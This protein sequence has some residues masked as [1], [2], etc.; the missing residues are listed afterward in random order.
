MNYEGAREKDRRSAFV[1]VPGKEDD[2]DGPFGCHC[3][4]PAVPIPHVERCRP[5]AQ[6]CVSERVRHH[7]GILPAQTDQRDRYVFRTPFW[8]LEPVL[9]WTR[10]DQARFHANASDY[11]MNV[12]LV[13]PSCQGHERIADGVEVLFFASSLEFFPKPKNPA[14]EIIRLHRVQV[15]SFED[16]PQFVCKVGPGCHVSFL[17]FDGS[18]E[19]SD[20][21]YH[22]S[23]AKYSMEKERELGI[24]KY[25]RGWLNNRDAPLMNHKYLRKLFELKSGEGPCDILCKVVQVRRQKRNDGKEDIL[26]FVWDGTDCVPQP[27]RSG[28]AESVFESGASLA[29][30]LAEGWG[31]LELSCE[32]IKSLKPPRIGTFLPVCFWSHLESSIP[33]VGDCI[34]LKSVL[35]WVHKGQTC[36]LFSSRSNWSYHQPEFMVEYS[37]RTLNNLVSQWAPENTQDLLTTTD[38]EH[39]PWST[40]REV[41]VDERPGKYRVLVQLVA[42]LPHDYNDWCTKVGNGKGEFPAKLLPSIGASPKATW[43]YSCKFLLRDATGTIEALLTGTSAEQF[44]PG[45]PPLDPTKNN[46]WKKTLDTRMQHLLGENTSKDAGEWIQCCV[47]GY[48]IRV[49]T[50]NEAR[51]YRIFGTMMKPIA[52]AS[53]VQAGSGV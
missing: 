20:I 38:Y 36:G 47:E 7:R 42:Y 29:T 41:L 50:P 35:V 24:L 33:K 39:I 53:H 16:K 30:E 8:S 27:L 21:P 52:P 49:G 12:R 10:A 37:C 48:R 15:T 25:M 4:R 46:I 9:A 11:V 17:L 3:A 6:A 26:M 23:T 2:V 18:E 5:D 43:I 22:T 28:T 34:R 19:G 44:F 32:E 13:D 51:K 45:L 40:L 31:S 14:G 1:V